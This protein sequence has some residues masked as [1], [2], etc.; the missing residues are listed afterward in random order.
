[1]WVYIQD[2]TG[3]LNCSCAATGRDGETERF[4]SHNHDSG[5]WNSV[6]F[7][8][9]FSGLFEKYF[10]C[11]KTSGEKISQAFSKIVTRTRHFGGEICVW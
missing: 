7:V 8:V 1:L 4:I 3:E 6:C 5:E 9:A 10:V 11:Q 2:L